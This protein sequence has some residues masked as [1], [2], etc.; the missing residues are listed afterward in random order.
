MKQITFVTYG[1]SCKSLQI[2]VIL[3][4]LATE[5]SRPFAALRVT[6]TTFCK[7]PLLIIFILSTE[8]GKPKTENGII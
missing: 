1:A 3:R 7:N 5:E 8:N 4:E 2:P 6:N